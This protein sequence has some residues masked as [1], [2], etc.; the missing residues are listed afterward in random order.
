MTASM[1]SRPDQPL[2]ALF[3]PDA[4]AADTHGI[5]ARL[6]A[7]LAGVPPMTGL[8]EMRAAYADGRM[9]LPVTPKAPAARTIRI[10]GPG[11]E[12]GLRILVPETVRGV[13]LHIHGGGWMLGTPDMQD[14][15][16]ETIGAAAGLAAVSVDY[17]LAPEHPFPAPVD[18]CVA[19]A[20][21]LIAH[22][23]AEFGAT[24]LA[25]GGESAGAHLAA[26]TLVR[27]RDAGQVAAFRAANLTFGYFDLSL[28][29]SARRARGTAFVDR[30]MLERMSDAYRGG[31]DGRDP[32]VS[33]LY[34]DLPGLPAALFSVGTID[35]L[36]DDTL[37]MHARWQAAANVAELA[38]YPGG[39]HGF[40]LLGGELAEA[41]NARIGR[42]L[43][44]AAARDGA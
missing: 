2:H 43:S 35:P 17:R 20:R 22:A 26:S 15:L 18:D 41:A 8:A 37:F 6:A 11:G 42:F 19:A 29:P 32:A 27:L 39:V 5:N 31:A 40:H 4:I 36:V 30:E 25:I 24:W 9:G 1:P 12:I 44:E 14:R 28:T 21:W 13:Y 7:T 16:L 23:E 33:P 3:R 38:V 34:A 10:P